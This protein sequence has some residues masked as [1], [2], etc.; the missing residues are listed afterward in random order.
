VSIKKLYLYA[1]LQHNSKTY[2]QKLVSCA[3]KVYFRPVIDKSHLEA[4]LFGPSNTSDQPSRQTP[5]KSGILI[6]ISK[7]VIAAIE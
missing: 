2:S 5:E 4:P 7:K 1:K 6:Q 3:G